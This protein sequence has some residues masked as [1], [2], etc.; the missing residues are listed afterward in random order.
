MSTLTADGDEACAAAV[1]LPMGEHHGRTEQSLSAHR[2]GFDGEALDQ[3]MM[4]RAGEV[5]DLLATGALGEPP[6]SGGQPSKTWGNQFCVGQGRK[7]QFRLTFREWLP[8]AQE[9]TDKHEQ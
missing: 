1:V 5:F 6:Q 8:R 9:W 3:L 2:A 7:E 4:C